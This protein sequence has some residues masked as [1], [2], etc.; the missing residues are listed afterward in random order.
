MTK[1]ERGSINI[2]RTVTS[3]MNTNEG[4]ERLRRKSKTAYRA[5]SKTTSLAQCQSNDWTIRNFEASINE[6]PANAGTREYFAEFTN[7]SKATN[8]TLETSKLSK[9]G[10]PKC[11]RR[12]KCR[13]NRDGIY[14]GT[15]SISL[16]IDPI[17][18]R[19][20]SSTIHRA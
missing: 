16:A 18:S 13:S 3:T 19:L 2:R 8:V 7:P 17:S 15:R 10:V 1:Y 4:N 14:R 20:R 9:A 12:T 6:Q 11:L 5:K